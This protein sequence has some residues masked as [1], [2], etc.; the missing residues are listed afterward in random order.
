MRAYLL[1]S[2]ATAYV[3]DVIMEF[4][5]YDVSGSV[6]EK[7]ASKIR[8]EI[9]SKVKDV[10]GE[11]IPA[12]N[13]NCVNVPPCRRGEYPSNETRPRAGLRNDPFGDRPVARRHQAATSRTC[14]GASAN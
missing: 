9:D 4:L 6:D 12:K 14:S 8:R 5:H 11:K 2:K 13:Q 7:E 3:D 1:G 10:R